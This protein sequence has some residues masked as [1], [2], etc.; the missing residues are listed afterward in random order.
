MLSVEGEFV[1]QVG[2]GKLRW[3]NGVAD[4]ANERIVVFNASGGG[5]FSGIA[6]HGVTGR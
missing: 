4:Y 2:V 3:P 1:R 6:M 5:S